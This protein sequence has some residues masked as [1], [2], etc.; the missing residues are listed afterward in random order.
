[1]FRFVDH[2][3]RLASSALVL[4]ATFGATDAYAQLRGLGSPGSGIGGIGSA[5]PSFGSIPRPPDIST[6]STTTDIQRSL[7]PLSTGIP[8]NGT[9]DTLERQL[10]NAGNPLTLS[11]PRLATARGPSRVPPA[12]ERRFVNN[13]VLVG[14]PSN[15][16]PQALEAL[17]Q[18]HRLTRL[19]SQAIG[20]TGVTLHRWR[21]GDQRLVG[22]VVRALEADG[23]ISMAQPNYRFTLQQSQPSATPD[24]YTLTKLNLPKAH[25]LA[26]GEGVLVAVI[27]NGIDISHP[28]LAG[29]IA[30]TFDAFEHSEPPAY[31]GTGTAGAIVAHARL[32]GVAPAARILAIRAFTAN[33]GTDEG[34]TINILK[35]IDWSVSYGAR[36]INMSFAGPP[37]PEISRSLAAASKKGVVL[38]A[39]AGNAGPNAGPLY[40]A[41]DPN[42]IAVT[43]T[44]A[45]DELFPKSNRGRHIAVAAPGVDILLPAPSRTYQMTTGTSVAAAHVSGIAALLLDRNPSLTP[46]AVRK[47]LLATAKDLGPKG[48]DD[49]FGAGLADAYRAIQAANSTTTRA[50]VANA[51]TR[52]PV[53][54]AAAR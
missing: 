27:D 54:N 11:A 6:G 14:L 2:C 50:P 51:A 10:G 31:H 13:E 45:N 41:A 25:R 17:A 8:T 32:T 9:L 37:D 46:Q 48:R 21:I 35:A 34:T 19:E 33:G 52:A 22:D 28:E 26:T 44:D 53:A 43:A 16:S 39:A 42:V 20:L 1:M 29:L 49:Q 36:I 3:R 30:G 15:L 4:A 23:G 18:R 40:P 47:I 24:Q 5:S 12:G 38:V 7:P